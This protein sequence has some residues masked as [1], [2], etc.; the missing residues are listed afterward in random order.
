MLVV[1]QRAWRAAIEVGAPNRTAPTCIGN[2]KTARAPAAT[3]GGENAGQRGRSGSARSGSRT[4]RSSRCASTHGP[5][6]RVNCNSSISVL[7]SSELHTD[8]A[9][10][11]PDINMIPAPVTAS[12]SAE[13]SHS[14]PVPSASRAASRSKIRS[15]RSPAI[16]SP[17]VDRS[18][19]ASSPSGG[20]SNEDQIQRSPLH[21]LFVE[22]SPSLY[23]SCRKT[24]AVA[25]ARGVLFEP[26]FRDSSFRSRDEAPDPGRVART[27][28]ER[29]PCRLTATVVV[30][31]PPR[32]PPQSIGSGSASCWVPPTAVRT[33]PI[34]PGPP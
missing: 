1:G 2:P 12:A 21:D 20:A 29:T 23:A 8:P 17:A 16:V 25:D 11:S 24:L 10:R 34:G 14:R 18:P 32:P 30:P 13:T 33:S 26:K 22:P 4:G 15:S 28:S 9:R 27:A 19:R 3:A 31:L 5:S 7:T 6:P